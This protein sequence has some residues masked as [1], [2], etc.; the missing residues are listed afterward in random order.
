MK[1][2]EKLNTLH[3]EG[4]MIAQLVAKNINKINEIIDYLEQL[5]EE[6]NE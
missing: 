4:D 6:T 3:T 2:P 5:K 1:I